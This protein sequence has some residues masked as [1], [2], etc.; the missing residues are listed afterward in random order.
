MLNICLRYLNQLKKNNFYD[1]LYVQKR[2]KLP[3]DKQKVS[4][5]YGGMIKDAIGKDLS[6]IQMPGIYKVLISL[7]VIIIKF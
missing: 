1:K 3:F 7:Y 6:Q 5:N 2:T 4:F